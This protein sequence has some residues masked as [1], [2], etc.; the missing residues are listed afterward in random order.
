MPPWDPLLLEKP[1][2]WRHKFL[3]EISD[4]VVLSA[5]PSGS[6]NNLEL[7]LAGH[8]GNNAVLASVSDVVETAAS[9]T[10]NSA[11]LSWSDK[12]AV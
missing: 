7:E 8:V 12:G 11:S 1:I 6:I 5:N 9:G 4:H 10:H 2:L 3:P